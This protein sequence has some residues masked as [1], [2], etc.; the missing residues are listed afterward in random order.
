M[1]RGISKV[2]KC[3]QNILNIWGSNPKPSILFIQEQ[4]VKNE[5]KKKN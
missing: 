4:K 5:Q 3:L 1:H 2:T